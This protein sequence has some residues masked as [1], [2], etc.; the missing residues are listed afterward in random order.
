MSTPAPRAASMAA[1]TAS[2]AVV[3]IAW[4]DAETCNALALRTSS[5]GTSRN[6]S[7]LAADP[8]RT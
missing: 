4:L 3:E 8:A 6:V 7:R 1:K 2:Q 5:S